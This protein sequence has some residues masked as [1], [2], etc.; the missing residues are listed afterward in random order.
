MSQLEAVICRMYVR[1]PWM[2]SEHEEP[3]NSKIQ[4]KKAGFFFAHFFDVELRYDRDHRPNSFDS[5]HQPR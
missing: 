5:G 3:E 4:R 2:E 1:D